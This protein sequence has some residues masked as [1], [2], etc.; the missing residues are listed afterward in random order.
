VGWRFR[1]KV[2]SEPQPARRTFS[3]DTVGPILGI[4]E[5]LSV[6]SFPEEK[7]SRREALTVPAV[8]RGR[9]LICSIATLP[10]ELKRV[11]DNAIVDS[12]LLRQID[13]D[14]ANV[15]TIAQTVEDLLFEGVSW[16][17]ILARDFDEFPISATHLDPLN[18]AEVPPPG[19]YPQL[20][21]SGLDPRH[22]KVIWVN[23]RPTDPRDLIRFDS[24]NGPLLRD[25]ARAIRRA[26]LLDKA[27]KMY[28]TD[29]RPN[30]YFTPDDTTQLTDEEI[31]TRINA[32]ISARSKRA[33]GWVEG[34]E[35]HTVD[36]P[37]PQQLQ[38]VELTNQVNLEIAI[39]IG[40]DPEDM[41]LNVTSR[42]YFNAQDRRLSRV[43]EVL[44]PYMRAVA[45]RLSMDSVT[46][47]G[48]CVEFDLSDYLKADPATRATVQDQY[49]T[50]GVLS[51]QEVRDQEGIPGKVPALP[52]PTKP[53]PPFIPAPVTAE[54]SIDQPPMMEP[55]Q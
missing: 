6:L 11:A 31:S 13:P 20:L 54:P 43:N 40:T 1:K 7:I 28:A 23:G 15:V 50:M 19:V 9:N 4:P 53:A 44:A 55:Q 10:L 48:Y 33:T 46:R 29:P 18:V 5:F 25:G 39:L 42:T 14:V 3:S 8:V 38:L 12:P 35:Y 16:W 36:S 2:A 17:L 41:G 37:N 47:R 22:D 52:A 34:M 24:P 27:A 26:I 49:I 51:P 32:W 45:D 21:P 30:D